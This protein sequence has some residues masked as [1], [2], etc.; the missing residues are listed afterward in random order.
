MQLFSFLSV[1]ESEDFNKSAMW[2][3]IQYQADFN[4]KNSNTDLYYFFIYSSCLLV[5]M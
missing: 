2:L 1:A 3:K 5:I 4:R